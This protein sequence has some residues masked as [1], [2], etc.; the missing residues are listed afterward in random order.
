MMRMRMSE[1]DDRDVLFIYLCHL[2]WRCCLVV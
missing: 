1:R 2:L